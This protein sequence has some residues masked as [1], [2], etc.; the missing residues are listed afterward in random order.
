MCWNC[1][2]GYA[3]DDEDLARE[4]ATKPEVIALAREIRDWYETFPAGGAL[5]IFTDDT[6]VEG[7]HLDFCAEALEKLDG[8]DFLTPWPADQVEAVRVRGQRILAMARD[9]TE[10]ERAVATNLD[11]HV[12]WR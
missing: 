10:L 1:V 7:G 12:E 2:L 11:P 4:T 9:L 8:S 6:N 3:D 5:H